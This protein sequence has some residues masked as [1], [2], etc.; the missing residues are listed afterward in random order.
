MVEG[1]IEIYE[2][3]DRRFDPTA[4]FRAQANV[5][6]RSMYDEAEDRELRGASR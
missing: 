4:A 3:E 6:D 2:T 5:A 1:S